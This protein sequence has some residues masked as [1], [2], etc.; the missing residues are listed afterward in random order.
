VSQIS[1]HTI[2]GQL[3][4]IVCVQ[5]HV[6]PEHVEDFIEASRKN[7]EGTRKNEPGNIRW[8]LLQAEDD[9][10]RFMLYE[11]YKTKEDFPKHQ[12]M[13]HFLEWRA[14]V[15]DW[16]AEPRTRVQYTNLHPSDELWNE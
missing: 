5:I 2:E 16:F 4:Y 12:Q 7:H 9:P 6:N 3:M 1:L 10:T 11:V 14:A 13:P 15:A 8:D